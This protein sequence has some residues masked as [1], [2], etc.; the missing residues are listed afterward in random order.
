VRFEI[1]FVSPSGEVKTVIGG[2]TWWEIADIHAHACC[3]EHYP[4]QL[5]A[6]ALRRAYESAGPGF[7][8]RQET[9]ELQTVH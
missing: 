6:A 2:L 8:H 4:L 1:T 3:A 9:F 5:N 7:F